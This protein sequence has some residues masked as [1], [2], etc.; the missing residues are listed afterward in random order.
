MPLEFFQWTK[1][2]VISLMVKITD[3][4]DVKI[5]LRREILSPPAVLIISY[6]LLQYSFDFVLLFKNSG[7][8]LHK[9]VRAFVNIKLK[10]QDH[11][12]SQKQKKGAQ[13]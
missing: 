3:H 9:K 5:A 1:L 10:V 2:T 13:T 8:R 7:S 4:Y 11:V 12:I 6:D